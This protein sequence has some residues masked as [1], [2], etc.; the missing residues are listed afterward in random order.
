MAIFIFTC[1]SKKTY[2][3]VNNADDNTTY[4]KFLITSMPYEF[5]VEFIHSVNNSPVRDY[6]EVRDD[7]TIYI[8]KTTYYGFGAGVQTELEGNENFSY[9]D[10]GEMIVSNIDKKIEPLTYF[11]GTISDHILYIGDEKISLTELCGKNAHIE[12]ILK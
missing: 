2:L 4:R 5:S 12:F 10:N 9:G 11:V 1:C 8:T 3:C 6:Y 7:K